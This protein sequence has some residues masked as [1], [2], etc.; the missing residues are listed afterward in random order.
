MTT[1][2]ANVNVEKMVEQDNYETGC[3]GG[4]RYVFDDN[5]TVEFNST[6][7]LLEKLGEY[8]SS[9]FDVDS[10]DFVK[11]AHNEIENNRFDYDQSEDGE[12]DKIDITPADPDGYLARYTFYIEDVREVKTVN[13]TFS[14]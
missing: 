14:L 12:G 5:F 7:D 11:H 10:E 2:I 9:A 6:Q 4:S 1:Y 13:Y 3:Y 8:L